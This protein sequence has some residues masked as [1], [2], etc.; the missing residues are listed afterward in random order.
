[1]KHKNNDTPSIIRN[2]EK[3]IND[4]IAIANTFNNFFTSIAE[5]VQSKIKF[6]NK[7]FRSFLST[8]NNDSFVITASNKEEIC[9]IISSCNINKSCGPNSIPTKILHLVKDQISKHLA[10]I[11]NSSFFAGIFLTIL[12]TAKVIPIHKKD[13]KLEVSN[14]RPISLLSNIDKIFEKSMHNRLIEFLEER[15]ILYYKQFG[16][17]KDFLSNHAILNLL[18][19]LQKALD[20]EQIACDIFI[21]LGKAS[22]TVSHDI[23]LEKLDY[24]GIRGISNDRLRSYSSNRSLFVSINDFNSDYKTIK[25]GGPQSSV[26]GPLLFL[27]FKND[28]NIAIKHSGNFSFCRWYLSFKWY[29]LSQVYK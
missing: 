7:S 11:S 23:L 16:F 6:S 28:L 15:Q 20:D 1:M 10:T 3:Y 14:Y 18:E 4:P 17:Q 22:D 25:Y 12:K 2:D 5:T 26:L 9:K 24:Y 21:D 8:K 19:I 13:S 27:I 29:R